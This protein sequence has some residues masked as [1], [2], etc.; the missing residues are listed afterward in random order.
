MTDA[1]EST[2]H[3]TSDAGRTA[4]VTVTRGAGK[5]PYPVLFAARIVL[6]DGTEP[7][8]R[9]IGF[10]DHDACLRSALGETRRA[11]AQR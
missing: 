4:V 1:I 3:H 10:R 8:V 5:G 11:L 9:T 2:T 6:D 7:E